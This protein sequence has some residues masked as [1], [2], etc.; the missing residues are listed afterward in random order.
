[1]EKPLTGRI[2][3][4]PNS[5]LKIT[6]VENHLDPYTIAG[7]GSQISLREGFGN[8]GE[9]CVI[10]SDIA[11]PSEFEQLLQDWSG[12]GKL[13]GFSL[14]AHGWA[15][16]VT[17]GG[18]KVL[19]SGQKYLHS[20]VQALLPYRL[21]AAFLAVCGGADPAWYSIVSDTGKYFSYKSDAHPGRWF[22]SKPFEVQ[23]PEKPGK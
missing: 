3:V 19:G 2:Y 6:S 15:G 13:L 23:R 10:V 9:P 21:A 4:I 18:T 17:I 12:N 1:L 14:L 5:V 7:F 22:T 20:D 11:K 8:D 16:S